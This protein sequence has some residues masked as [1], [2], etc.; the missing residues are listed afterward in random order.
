M[1]AEIN[2]C[3]ASCLIDTGAT[4]TMVSPRVWD[5]Q[6]NKPSKLEPFEKDILSVTGSTIDV[7]GKTPITIH[8][9]GTI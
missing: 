8:V 3:S 6:L 5:I 4:L 1:P 7:K 2:R 9:G